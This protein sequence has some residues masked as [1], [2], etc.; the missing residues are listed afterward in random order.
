MLPGSA[1]RPRPFPCHLNEELRHL[2]LYRALEVP[3][4]D[5]PDGLGHD[6]I[7]GLTVDAGPI[8]VVVARCF[9]HFDFRENALD[10]ALF[11]DAD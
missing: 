7:D 1:P 6:L 10:I 2:L 11:P 5:G 9:L 4:G 8:V 3:I